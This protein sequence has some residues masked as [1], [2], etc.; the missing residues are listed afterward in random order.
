M[1]G[2]RLTGL[3]SGMDTESMI[4]QLMEARKKKV[5]LKKK[6]QISLNYKQDKWKDLNKKLKNLQSKYISNMRFS[7]SY[8]KKTSAVSN[9]SVASVITGE[10]AVNGVQELEVKQMA[11][12]GY[13]TGAKL[14]DGKQGYTAT[15][16]LSE[17]GFEDGGSFKITAGSKEVNVDVT[18]DTTI[19]DVL[20]KLKEAGLNANFDEKNQRLFVSSKESGAENDFKIE[21]TAGEGQ[22]AIDALGL[23]TSAGATKIAGQNAKILLNG[24]EFTSNSNTFEINGLT[25]TALSETKEGEKVTISTENDVSGV[26][27]MVKNFL[28]EYNSIINEMDKLYNAPLTGSLKPM[29][30]E[31]KDA[32]SESEAKEWEEKLRDSSLRRDE[33]LGSVAEAMKSAMSATYN[34]GGKTMSI[35][36]LGIRN[37]GYF[38]A[39][40]NEKNA[41]YIDGDPDSEGTSS[42]PDKLKSMIASNPD[43]VIS[44]MT[45]LSQNLYSNMDKVS[46]SVEGVRSYGSFYD[47]KKMKSEYDDYNSKI[48]EME[49]KLN[50]YEDSWYAKFA[51]MESAMAK[52]QKNTSA[53]TALIGGGGY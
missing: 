40:E 32:V 2:T 15:T 12:T 33:N 5:D 18:A 22:A 44:L 26:Y 1:A 6:D 27:D 23:S 28:K 49:E 39:A 10:N 9:S 42:N 41:F 21:A 45:Q 31:E 34:V 52:M 50:K 30:Q 25:I 14:G 24:A 47:D 37:L 35:Y 43:A 51:K 38:E 20:T 53:V 8:A 29:T 19:S 48:A 11:K 17:L 13:L 46:K 7:S 16:K 4:S 3:I 36:D